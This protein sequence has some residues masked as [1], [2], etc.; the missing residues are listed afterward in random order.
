MPEI[1][2]PWLISFLPPSAAHKRAALA[3]SMLLLVAFLISLPSAKVVL[4]QLEIYMPLVATVMFLN[5]LMTASLLLSLFAVVRSRALLSL[6]NG[7]LFTA[8]IV[9]VYGLVWPGAFHP[10]GLF[11]AGP[12]TRPWLYLTWYA[13]LPISVIAYALLKGKE[14][15]TLPVARD[16]VLTF[17]FAS[18]ACT[19]LIVCG[20]TWFLTRFPDVLPVLMTPLGR[21]TGF[22]HFGTGAILFASITACVLQW[23]RRQRSVLDLWLSLVTLAWLLGSIMLIAT[24][25][26]YDVAWYAGPGF[27]VVS[28]TLVLLVLLSESVKLHAQLAISVLAQRRER[29]GRRLSMDAMSAALAHEFKQPLSAIVT[30]ADAAVRWLGRTPPNVGQAHDS[31]KRITNDA[32][33]AVKII[34]SVREMFSNVGQGRDGQRRTPVDTN[35]LIRESIAILRGELDAA[36]IIAQLELAKEVPLVSADSGQLQQV[37][38]N[39]IT[40]A[41]DAMRGITDRARVLKLTSRAL[42]SN[43]VAVS[44]ED[45]GPG[46]DPGHIDRIFQA[47]FTTKPNGMGLGLAICQSIVESHGGTMTVGANMPHGSVFRINL[48][49]SQTPG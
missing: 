9:A 29:E 30:S 23:R 3:V 31:L 12:Q 11:G 44:I 17:I 6:A 33:R 43:A 24:G 48:P 14:H 34:Q 41:A 36:K 46:V 15:T 38:L 32:H 37:L 39:L 20:L 13:G 8:L 28:A 10:T 26:R 2:Q 7:Y 16:P 40:N 19:I 35:E 49:S 4:P 25:G 27:S 47:F 42:E 22:S 45:T 18:I 5:D 1:Q 21:A